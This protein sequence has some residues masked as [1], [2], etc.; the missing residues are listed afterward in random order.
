MFCEP[1]RKTLYH[2]FNE[3]YKFTGFFKYGIWMS[4]FSKLKDKMEGKIY[5]YYEFK[6]QRYH[7]LKKPHLFDVSM[8]DV[9]IFCLT[10]KND[11]KKMWKD[12]ANNGKGLCIGLSFNIWDE[13]TQWKGTWDKNDFF[14][15][16]YNDPYNTLWPKRKVHYCNIGENRSTTAYLIKVKYGGGVDV[17]YCEIG[18]KLDYVTPYPEKL[19]SYKYQKYVNE[20]ETR[21]MVEQK[22]ANNKYYTIPKCFVKEVIF[23][24]RMSK[25]ERDTLIKLIY[26]Y[27][28]YNLQ[29]FEEKRCNGRIEIVPLRHA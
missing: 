2:Y 26:D 23:G 9:G 11:N 10:E 1:A 5:F 29:F 15:L 7:K 22:C 20:N 25:P 8:I 19:F 18:G 14:E 12:Y 27:G 4:S 17:P 21:F 24:N 6:Q 3:E 16:P 28:E 13:N